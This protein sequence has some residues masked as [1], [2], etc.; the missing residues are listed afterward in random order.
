M[1]MA[2]KTILAFCVGWGALYAGQ[3]YWLAAITA[4][5]SENSGLS[6]APPVPVT[7]A[8]EIDPEKLRQAI[9]P[10]VN[11]DTRKYERLAIEGMLRDVDRQ[12]RNALSQV[13]QPMHIPGLPRH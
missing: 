7:P 3:H 12:N 10:P 6:L 1:G 4:Q 5:V 8:I 2:I 9:N 13:P 11:I